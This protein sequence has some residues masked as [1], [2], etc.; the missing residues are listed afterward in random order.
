MG[1][2]VEC[3]V[4]DGRSDG[5]FATAAAGS[6]NYRAHTH[7]LN[8]ISSRLRLLGES[9]VFVRW[10]DNC[11]VLYEEPHFPRVC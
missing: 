1:H 4:L 2:T 7:M 8:G 6:E 5:A 3:M 11:A 9:E 10:E